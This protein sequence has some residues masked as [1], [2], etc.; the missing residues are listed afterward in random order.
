MPSFRLVYL[1]DS[2]RQDA[3]L[4][5]LYGAGMEGCEEERIGVGRI[6]AVAYFATDAVPEELYSIVSRA[7]GELDGVLEAVADHDWNATWREGVQPVSIAPGVWV[8]P[9]WRPPPE[10]EGDI[11][12]RIEPAMA[13]G[14]G[15]HET[16]R[17][18]ARFVVRLMASPTPPRRLL[19]IGTGSG[20]L[21]FC[22][23]AR[24]AHTCIGVDIDPLCRANLVDNM[25]DNPGIRP[26]GFVIGPITALAGDAA[27]DAVVMNMIFTESAPL[28]PEVRRLLRP[29]GE[30]IWSGLL[31]EDRP[32]TITA[33]PRHD[34][35]LV[36]E[37]TEGEW[38]AGRFAAQ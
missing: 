21:C 10:G 34:F 3:A 36:E 26:T 23:R 5:L 6:R 29:R 22:A 9:S 38:W 19:D 13:F 25:R 12:I 8:S 14:T 18:A 37:Y 1:I 24:G 7:G 11:W 15:H 4:G 28:L 33:A 16:T 2:S 17:L 20:V 35:A 27:F 31:V 32:Q 30:L